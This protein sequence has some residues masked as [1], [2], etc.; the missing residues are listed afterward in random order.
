MRFAVL[1]AA[2]LAG[3]PGWAGGP[4]LE[5]D[6]R[7]VWR[8]NDPRFG[9]FSGI[10][11]S[12]DGT[13]FLAIS[14]H[15]SWATAEVERSDG[16]MT[17]V[18]KTGIGPLRAISGAALEDE[19][20]DAEGLAFDARGRAWVSFEAFHRIRRYDEIDGPATDIEGHPA[21]PRLQRNSGLE[22]L[23]IDASGTLYAVPERSGKWEWPFPV[24]RLRDG[25]WDTDLELRRDGTFLVV[26]ADFGPDGRFY[27]LERDFQWL[28]GFA[29]RI[30]SFRLGPDGF[31]DELTLLQTES[32][33]LDNFEGISVWRDPAGTI[34]ATLIA[35]DNFM[36]FQSTVVAEYRLAED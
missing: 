36:A 8:G 31:E 29:S 22:A 34:R 27:L 19:E 16:R 18:S 21:F 6:A 12:E 1:L 9:G 30:R 25:R 17:G 13:G 15:G 24:F 33:T 2:V 10:A 32:G 3:V 28:G 26:D 7:V 11:M 14:D 5:L 35:D 20:V 23:A 4:R